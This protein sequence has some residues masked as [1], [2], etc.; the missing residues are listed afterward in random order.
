MELLVIL[1]I[2]ILVAA[3]VGYRLWKGQRPGALDS[4]DNDG[5]PHRDDQ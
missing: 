2:A 3:M 1:V 4:P 5:N